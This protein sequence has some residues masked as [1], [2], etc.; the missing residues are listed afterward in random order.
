MQRERLVSWYDSR[1]TYTHCG[2]ETLTH[3]PHTNA[4]GSTVDILVM[5][6]G[7]VPVPNTGWDG[8]EPGPSYRDVNPSWRVL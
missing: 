1:C 4:L 2:L 8:W 6:C 3:A 5:C 7:T